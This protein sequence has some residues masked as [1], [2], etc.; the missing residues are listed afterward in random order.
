MSLRRREWPRRQEGGKGTMLN[1]SGIRRCPRN[2][3]VLTSWE[4]YRSG[5]LTG[6]DSLADSFRSYRI[7]SRPEDYN[8]SRAPK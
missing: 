5:N 1:G 4:H 6:R 7:T 8:V 3:A 2:N